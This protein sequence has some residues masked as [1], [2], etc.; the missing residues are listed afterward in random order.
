MLEILEARLLL[1][2]DPLGGAPDLAEPSS[3]AEPAIEV[4]LSSF[5]D[6]M[7]DDFS[8][9]I[10]L[11]SVSEVSVTGINVGYTVET[12]EPAQSW[13]V[14]SA[15][16][17]WTAPSSS[18]VVFDTNG[19]EF[20]TFL[21]LATGFSVNALSVL[22]QNDDGGNGLQSLIRWDVVAGTE[23][24]I[25]VD[26][27]G[28]YSGNIVLNIAP[29]ATQVPFNDANLQAAVEAELG[30]A[31]PT[32]VDMR[33]LQ[34]LDA[35]NLNITDLTGLETATNLQRLTLYD[36]NI[37][38]LGALVGLTNLTELN[39]DRNQVTELSYLAGLT[40][41][42]YLSLSGNQITD[43]H[44][45][46]GLVNLQS[47]SLTANLVTNFSPVSGLTNLTYLNLDRTQVTDLGILSNLTN[48]TTLSAS[49][50]PS[51][52]NVN[53]LASLS[54]LQNVYLWGN[55]IS[56]I[57]VLTGHT[58]L[59][60]LFINDNILSQAAYLNDIPLIQAN[61]P[62]ILLFYDAPGLI[63]GLVW[64]D[65]DLNGIRDT[66]ESILNG[67]TVY[68]D[69][70][71]NG[72]HD[73]PE[74]STL[75]ASGTF[76]FTALSA[77]TYDVRV[78]LPR[79]WQPTYPSQNVHRVA[80]AVAQ[81]RSDVGFGSWNRGRVVSVGQLNAGVAANDG[82]TGIGYIM[83]SEESVHA[84]FA[85]TP[86]Y[87]G[88][89]DHLIAI[90]YINAQWYIDNNYTYVAFTPLA[91]D[92]IVAQVDFTNDTVTDLKGSGGMIYGLEAGYL[93]GDLVITANVLAGNY[94]SGE[95][96][97]TGHWFRRN[98][99]APKSVGQLNAGIAAKDDA[100]GIG[101][102]MYSEESVHA[103]FASTPPYAH[104]SDH[105]IAVKYISGQWYMDNNGT[106]VAFTLLA[107]DLAV[108][109]VD[110]TND[111]VTDLKG[112]Q[113]MIYGL[114][115]GY[116]DGDLVITANELG[117]HPNLGEFNV[118]GHWFKRNV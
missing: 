96:G 87:P 95:F 81:N 5:V 38:S 16:W 57:S 111:S 10:D 8:D 73:L 64:N 39:L 40:N 31:N 41:L 47:L 28:N 68:L 76:E 34:F 17:S 117:G 118:T 21:T 45:L 85:S 65:V 97:V 61:N 112:S 113:G 3:S 89:S 36:N 101:Y 82:A 104:N 29:P 79:G 92:L 7:N 86:P 78:E 56:D 77:Q 37:S 109:Q 100:T 54:S 90:K 49:G 46:G 72:F 88:N 94:N 69:I 1:S 27:W 105:L 75:T 18:T 20:D 52:S 50:N 11:G 58:T 24:H 114:E 33:S 62:G 26:G 116:L 103:R 110:F 44:P 25:S 32:N 63:S 66:D 59:Q 55:R 60:T 70:N 99:A 98:E 74:P 115:T 4:A 2:A 84:R 106:Y 12:G 107:S 53:P 48:L 93:D 71:Q 108:A 14:H 91:S 51:L 6:V 30:I 19:S 9:R 83:Y 23:Y 35:N 102:I 80:L 13:V 42:T 43:V 22:A 15:W 67:W